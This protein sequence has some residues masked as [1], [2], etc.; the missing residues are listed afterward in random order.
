MKKLFLIIVFVQS[1]QSFAQPNYPTA[2]PP[3]GNITNIEFFVDSK[4]EFGTGIALTGFP[5]ASSNINA[6]SG[7]ANIGTVS[8]GFHRIYFRSKDANGKWSITENAF[9]DNYTVPVYATAPAAPIDIS[10]IE[11]FVDS[12]PEFGSGTPLTGFT[13]S[14]NINAFVGTANIGTVPQG[15]HQFYIRSKD[16]NNKWSLTNNTQFDN[17][18]VPLYATAPP[19]PTPITDIEFFIDNKP[20]FASGTPLT[21]FTPSSN[22][23]AFSGT[24]N[25]GTVPQGF[26]RFYIRSK[27]AINKW[28]ITNNYFFDNYSVPLY[29]NAPAAP[30]NIVQLEYFIDNNDL[31]FGNCNPISIAGNIANI[32][33]LNANVNVTGLPQGTHRLY[34]RSKD[35]NNKWSI[36]NLSIFDNS[37]TANY[38]TAPSPAPAIANMEYYIDTDPGFGNATPLTVPGNTGNINN[39]SI[40][41]NLSGSLSIGTHYLCI[42]SKQN[43][44][45]VTNVVPFSAT[46]ATPLT[47]QYIKAQLINK[48]TQVSWGTAQ[49]ANTNFFEIE[50]SIDARTFKKI[51]EV[52]AAGNSTTSKNYLFNHTNPVNGFNYYRIK[53]IDNNGSFKYSVVVTILKKDDLDKTIVAPNPVKDVLHVVEPSSTFITNAEIYSTTGTLILRKN[54]NADV[55]VYSI[56]VNNLPTAQYVLKVN[57]NG[58]VKSYS[59]IKE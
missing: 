4:P 42:R 18:T 29:N 14:S 56:P 12:K 47:W 46:V 59:F 52:I 39:Y 22:I 37:I 2:P 55:Q 57:Y 27:D 13:P 20:E 30:T 16:L 38:P 9:F 51:G 50:H 7:T 43:P 21:G 19:S 36:T 53:Q 34:I 32:T 8:Q 49:E 17:Y 44:W 58:T 1:I 41:L 5:P 40:N 15:F 31:G 24:A 25:I 28:S 35:A 26:H 45:S 10:T 48:Q 11:F 54:I 6:F 3:S 23:S 33:N